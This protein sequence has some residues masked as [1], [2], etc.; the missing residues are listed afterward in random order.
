MLHAT[1]QNAAREGLPP[2]E[3]QLLDVLRHRG[4]NLAGRRFTRRSP[5][6]SFGEFLPGCPGGVHQ[7]GGAGLVVS[8]PPAP[9]TVAVSVGFVPA[10]LPMK[11]SAQAAMMASTSTERKASVPQGPPVVTG[12]ATVFFS[13]VS[14]MGTGAG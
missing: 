8:G 14:Q 7:A 3:P 10:T 6:D 5:R 2:A 1:Q 4:A 13:G 9:T 11:C 12:S